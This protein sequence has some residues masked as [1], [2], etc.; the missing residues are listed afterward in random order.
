MCS[1]F[2]KLDSERLEMSSKLVTAARL[3]HQFK[4]DDEKH[5]RPLRKVFIFV[6]FTCLVPHILKVRFVL[7]NG[8][9]VR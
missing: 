5:Q 1:H 3:I 4:E 9:I 2:D 6:E 8:L 7:G